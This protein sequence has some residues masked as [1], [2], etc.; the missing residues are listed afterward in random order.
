MIILIKMIILM[1]ITMIT[2]GGGGLS[3]CPAQKSS[4][5]LFHLLIKAFVGLRSFP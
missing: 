5:G 4:S 1:K 2:T 3:L